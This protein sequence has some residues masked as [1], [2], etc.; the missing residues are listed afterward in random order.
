MVEMSWGKKSKKQDQMSID[1]IGSA[2][3]FSK[4]Y[5]GK[6]EEDEEGLRTKEVGL[7]TKE[8]GLRTKEVK[9]RTKEVGLRTKEVG[10]K[11]RR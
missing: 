2:F 7:R 5:R 10:L 9:L 1:A 11:P 3:R 6:T 4:T 8:V